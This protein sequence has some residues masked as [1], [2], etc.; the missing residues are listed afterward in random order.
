MNGFQNVEIYNLVVKLL[1]IEDKAAATNGTK[2][3]W[4]Q[5]L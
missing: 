5:F 2:G 1:G 4:E 3:F